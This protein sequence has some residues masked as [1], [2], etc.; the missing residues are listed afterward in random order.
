MSN[1][2]SSLRAAADTIDV[3]QQSVAVS[4]NNVMNASSAGYVRQRVQLKARDFEPGGGLSGGVSLGV[5]ETARD[6]YADQAVRMQMTEAGATAQS[7]RSLTSLEDVF[8]VNDP[9]GIAARL[10]QLFQSFSSW[11]LAP[12]SGSAR[13]GVISA[14]EDLA[15]SF[16][17]TS[18]EM[19]RLTQQTDQQ[20][21]GT[22]SEI[23]ALVGQVR[24]YNASRQNTSVDDAGLDAGVTST[25]EK[26]SSLADVQVSKQQNGTYTLLLDGQVQ[27]LV[28]DRQTELGVAFTTP[29]SPAPINIGAVPPA[30]IVNA[31]TGADVN[32]HIKSGQL[33][34]LLEFRN[35]TLPKYQ[36]DAQST[37]ELNRLAKSVA[38]RVNQILQTGSSPPATPLFVY[39]SSTVSISHTIAVNPAITP[40]SLQAAEPGPP[41]VA[42]GKTLQLAALAA[43]VK[44]EDKIDGMS[45]SEFLGKTTA[46]VGQELLYA[47]SR[48]ESQAQLVA[49]AQ[50][51]RAQLSGV[52]LDEEAVRLIEF[53]R[54]YQAT[55]RMISMVNEM[56][57]IVLSM[58]SR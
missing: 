1:L 35:N 49:Q 29:A 31:S 42:N 21:R 7:T 48:N 41:M 28:G 45:Y 12:N 14:A 16:G 53:Q 25:L 36:G 54:A 55:A 15:S 30:T 37:G 27:L 22:V 3:L 2:L 57:E 18:R 40:D 50:N 9:N 13:S 11:S 20:V 4:Q 46:D 38:D 26:L 44:T 32:S 8:S 10:D 24:D 51:L 33:G 23:N 58:G 43:P 17:R 52:S 5:V 56:A 19:D 39:G 6:S 47:K 34:A